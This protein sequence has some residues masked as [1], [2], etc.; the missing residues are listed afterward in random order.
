MSKDLVLLQ[1]D[2]LENLTKIPDHSIDLLLTDP[3]YEHV[4]GGMKSKVYNKSGTYRANSYM[5]MKMSQFK[6]DNIF[7]FL[8]TV[9]PKL[10]KINMFIFCSKLQLAHYFNYINQHKKLKFDLLIWDKSSI[11]GKYGM[12]S[13]KFFTQDIEYVVRIYESGV[14]LNKI[15]NEDHTKSNSSYYMKRQKFTQPHGLHESMKP[16]E[17]L[18][19]YIELT[20][21]ENDIVLDPF[22]GSGSTGIA[23]L[24]LNRRFIGMELD[25]KYFGVAKGR[26]ENT[27]TDINKHNERKEETT[28]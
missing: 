10:K 25:D 18:Q 21:N 3:P 23:A 6:H 22:M 9:I 12:K 13:S 26:I 2:C 15:W 5:N 17:L 16:V 11:E 27:F 8:N 20:S 7:N 4:M 24:N 1:G 19:R 28:V 14:S